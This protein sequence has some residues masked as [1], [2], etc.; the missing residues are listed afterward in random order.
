MELMEQGSQQRSVAATLM[1]EESS[2]S[3]SILT[4]TIDSR[5][6]APNGDTTSRSSRMNLVDLAGAHPS[7]SPPPPIHSAP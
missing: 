1:N 2:R 3:H 7:L 6:R 5:E 4:A